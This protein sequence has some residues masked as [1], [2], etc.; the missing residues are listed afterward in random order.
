MKGT[1]GPVSLAMFGRVLNRL[2]GTWRDDL[3]NGAKA[4][5]ISALVSEGAAWWEGVPA[6]YVMR[7]R[8]RLTEAG[9]EVA[10]AH[11]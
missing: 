8:L 1:A 2:E 10:R 3:V 7:E 9:A 6:G 11:R 4:G 5:V